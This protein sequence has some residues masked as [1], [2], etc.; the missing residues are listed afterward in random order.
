LKAG[1][2]QPQMT[3][4]DADVFLKF[5]ICA[6]LRNLRLNHSP[7][8]DLSAIARRATGEILEKIGV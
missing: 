7:S 8:R 4:M 6:N 1:R 3:Q 5:F 2:I